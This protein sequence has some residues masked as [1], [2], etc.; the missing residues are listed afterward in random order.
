M[1]SKD[2]S[3][4]SRAAELASIVQRVAAQ[5]RAMEE[6]VG[7]IL[8]GRYRIIKALGSGGMGTVFLA[9]HVHLGRLTAVKLLRRDLGLDPD[10][11]AR[12]RREALLAA[13][14]THANVAQIYDFDRTA[15]GEFLI[16]MEYVEGETV[17]QRLHRSGP[18]DLP[19]TVEVLKGVASGLDRA[20]SLGIVHRDLKP[21]N[22]MLAKDGSV[23][24]LD[25]GVARSLEPVAEI[26]SSGVVVGTPAYMSPEQLTGE[27]VGP[28]T[29]IYSL[30]A[31]VYEMLSGLQPH[32][33]NTF[34]EFRAK[35]L[36]QLPTDVNRLRDD[37]SP[38]LAQVVAKALAVDPAARWG[39]AGEFAEAAHAALTDRRPVVP[40]AADT[41]GT[42]GMDRWEAH[43]DQLRVAGRD[44]EMRSVRDAWAAAR[45]GRAT[46]LWI[47]G[48]EGAGKSS[49]FDLAR[50]E[51]AGDGRPD[52]VGRGYEADVVRPYGSWIGILRSALERA[53]GK[54]G[55]W[56][57]IATLTDDIPDPAPPDRATLY[58][59]VGLLFRTLGADGPFLIGLEDLDW[60][61][62]ASIS[63]LEFVANDVTR[64]PVLLVVSAHTEAPPSGTAQA[65]RGVRERIRRRDG[66][67]WVSLRP[68]SY[69]AV[70][71]WLHRAL[72]HEA[73]D[74]LVRFVYG[75]TEGNAFFIEQ[76]IRSMVERNEMDLMSDDTSRV[77][78]AYAPPPEAVAD[79]VERRLKGM[80]S[81]AR[82]ILQNAAV[83][84]REFD[85]DLVVALSTRSED[86]VLDALDEAKA[87]GVLTP[88]QRTDGDWYRFTHNKVA[89]VLAQGLN[90]RRRRKLHAK[91]ADA[92]AERGA[93]ASGQMAWHWFHAGEMT[94]ASEAARAA[95]R[96]ALFVHDYDDALTFGAMAAES[97]QTSEEKT[98]AHELRGDALRR[99]DR[100]GEAAAAYARARLAGATDGARALELRRKE[101]RTSLV[102]GTIAAGAAASE[103]RK[104]AEGGR[105][106]PAVQRAALELLLAEALAGAGDGFAACAS[107]E[108]ACA[109][110]RE[111][112]DDAQL[113]DALLALGQGY[114]ACTALPEAAAAAK[115]AY[116]TYLALGDA[117]GAA[118]AAILQAH[119]AR[120]SGER[121]AAKEALTDARHQAT[122]SRVSRLMRAVDDEQS[123]LDAV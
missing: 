108:Q 31:V 6:R 121:G 118:R 101:L 28:A 94:K 103:A 78:L 109:H 93:T 35:R 92:L 54:G 98:D 39:S 97:A 49:F 77:S 20:H 120:A 47:E 58:D 63:L 55:P 113:A 76:V 74:E 16:A 90:V 11:E 72:G 75:N 41:R 3:P 61:D 115:Q 53:T 52:F 84:G 8:A 43:F 105:N 110:A 27:A 83:I 19:H 25:F 29:D 65:A 59:E 37:C 82:E 100:F 71:Q 111:A 95:A 38:A 33:G 30:G 36:M 9:E 112:S 44:R 10:A 102:A 48:E 17:G 13:R 22:A 69:E 104:L 70:A 14:I 5:Q 80:S 34:A 40:V 12:F 73:P 64:C 79:V 89:Q 32:T 4:E 2:I 88:M 7:Q 114:L 106:L 51:A 81:A 123:R 56:S 107:A 116:A 99:L 26:T 21:E 15:E 57:A 117:Y 86:A 122:R 85:V 66:V 87:A 62:P 46:L 42:P 23:K 45:A 68:L 18:F 67:V 50:R 1:A 60:C 96:H 119:A 91:V 24:L